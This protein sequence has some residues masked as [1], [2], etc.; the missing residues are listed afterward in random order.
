MK[1]KRSI[2]LLLGVVFAFSAMPAQAGFLDELK[3]LDEVLTAV[4]E[5]L[6]DPPEDTSE[7]IAETQADNS[8]QK[9]SQNSTCYSDEGRG[10]PK[11]NAA[12]WKD[13]KRHGQWTIREKYGRVSEGPYVDGKR[14]GQ[15]THR[16]RDGIVSY[17]DGTG[18]Y[19]YGVKHGQWTGVTWAFAG[20]PGGPGG[21]GEGPYV[22]GVPH[23]QWTFRNEDG[24]VQGGGLY[25]V[26]KRNG[27][28]TERHND[29]SVA[30]GWYLD[31]E[32]RGEWITRYPDG[33]EKYGNYKPITGNYDYEGFAKEALFSQCINFTVR[34]E[35]EPRAESPQSDTNC[36]KDGKKNG[37]WAN[38]WVSSAGSYG[39]LY[40][41]QMRVGQYVNG[42]NHGKWTLRFPDG[43][44]TI[45]NYVHGESQ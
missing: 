22:A 5:L 34:E 24:R 7:T 29:G 45:Y 25:V 32:R 20:G 6:P 4:S 3:K 44:S 40:G 28:W 14:H 33:T 43:D 13:G 17:R 8:T 9:T 30:Q 12:C 35:T 41:G 23:G 26:R 27:P 42:K 37:K 15:W 19:V 11:S 39:K 10:T 21:V 31:G 16:N 2:A 1:S 18:P 36:W 38:L